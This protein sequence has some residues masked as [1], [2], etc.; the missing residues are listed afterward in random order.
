MKSDRGTAIFSRRGVSLGG[1][2]GIFYVNFAALSPC[3]FVGTGSVEVGQGWG[4]SAGG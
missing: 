4:L 3:L 2:C 1:G